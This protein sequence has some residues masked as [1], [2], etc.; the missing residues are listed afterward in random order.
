MAATMTIRKFND[1][2]RVIARPE[3][4]TACDSDAATAAIVNRYASKSS[5]LPHIWLTGGSLARSLGTSG[6]LPETEVHE[7]P[8]DLLLVRYSTSVGFGRTSFAVNSV[9]MRNRLWRGRIVAITNG[10][11][12]GALEIAPRAHPNDGVF[13]VVEVADDM[14]WRQRIIARSRLSTGSHIPHPSIR[15]RQSR[16]DS[17]IFARPM[18]LYLDGDFAGSFAEVNVTIES[19]SLKLVI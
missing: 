14:S 4:V 10:G 6:T 15:V 1:W 12:I 8:I 11:Y 2:G 13:D 18:D 16:S 5:L 17:W 7:L 9:V 19:D 3:S